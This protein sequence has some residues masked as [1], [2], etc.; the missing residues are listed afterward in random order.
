MENRTKNVAIS[1][2]VSEEDSEKIHALAEEAGMTVSE[3]LAA[4]GTKKEIIRM[5]DLHELTRELKA[6]GNNLNRL[7]VLANLGEIRTVHLGDTM[8]LYLEIRDTL[9]EFFDGRRKK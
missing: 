2:R 3:Y 4:C 6:Q 1:F 7:T 9:K 5:P 8:D